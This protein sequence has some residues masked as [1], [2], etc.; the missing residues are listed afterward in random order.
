M[1]VYLGNDCFCLQNSEIEFSS[2]DLKLVV[3]ITLFNKEYIPEIYERIIYKNTNTEKH[4]KKT[5]TQKHIK[6]KYAIC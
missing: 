5:S 4:K 6:I 2:L 3:I 1:Y